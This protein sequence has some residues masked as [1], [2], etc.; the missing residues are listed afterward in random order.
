MTFNEKNNPL[1]IFEIEIQQLKFSSFCILDFQQNNFA[2]R[3]ILLRVKQ[4]FGANQTF[5]KKN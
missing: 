2:T 5:E 3:S 4:M 1:L